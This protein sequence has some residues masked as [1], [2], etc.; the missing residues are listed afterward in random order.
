MNCK[1][2]AGFSMVELIVG[3]ALMAIIMSGTVGMLT[4]LIQ[5]GVQGVEL[6]DKQQEARWAVNMIS[7]D[8]RYAK[9]FNVTADEKSIVDVNLRDSTG[10]DV[11][12]RYSL[13]ASGDKGNSVLQRQVFIPS[14]NTTAVTSLLGNPVRGFVKASDFAVK[15]ATAGG[16]VTEV[17]IVYKIRRSAD[18]ASAATAETK[19]FPVNE[20]PTL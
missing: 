6:I 3:L 17:H 7:Q 13:V 10:R 5:H 12:V 15:T 20:I 11:R 1:Q 16:I 9:T 2:Q 4:N 14:G 18:D 8:L 19:V